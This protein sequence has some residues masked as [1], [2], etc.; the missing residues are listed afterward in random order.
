[1]TVSTNSRRSRVQLDPPPS[2]VAIVG[3]GLGGVRTAEQL[4]SAGYDGRITVIGAEPH[5][6]YDRPP[7]SKQLLSGAWGQERLVL[8]DRGGF[9]ELDVELRLGQPAVALRPG[10]VDLADG[11]TVRADCFVV[12]TGS[13]S[14]RLSGQPDAVHLLRTLDD[15]LRLRDAL[16]KANSLAIVGAG[17]IGAEVASVATQLGIAVSVLEAL[18]LPMSRVLGQAGGRLCA[19]LLLE[20][21]VDL[22]TG[23]VLRGFQAS[24]RAVTLKLGSGRVTA[25][26]VLVGVGGQP[27]S[28]WLAS[29]LGTSCVTGVPCD[30]S[31]RV[32]GLDRVW[33][34]GDVA[35]WDDPVRGQ[36]RVEHWTNAAEQAAVV[37][38]D[39]LGAPTP[40]RAVPYVWSDQFGLKI[41]ALGSPDN[42]ECVLTLHGDGLNGGAVRG[43]VLAYLRES[44]LVGVVAFGAP[45]L[46]GQ[47][48]AA[49]AGNWYRDDVLALADSASSSVSS[50]RA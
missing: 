21:G 38:S 34:V 4:R 36:R 20:N 46:S 41:Q 27:N 12:A 39:I 1:L 3:A 33:A 30:S 25:D 13:R 26:A 49:L 6:P 37:A 18:P 48:R 42:A 40:T 22:R 47:Y 9:D 17:F 23:A 44:R 19:R 43:T 35:A 2:H 8:R 16:A 24:A 15:G 50:R 14:R 31:G 11:T 32:T 10:L 45:R 28:D 7:L 5:L 29:S